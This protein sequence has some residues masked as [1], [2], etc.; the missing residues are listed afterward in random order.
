MT[1]KV[2]SRAQDYLTVVHE[3]RVYQ[4]VN[5]QFLL[6]KHPTESVINFLKDLQNDYRK[7]LRKLIK[8]NKTDP[9]I[10]EVVARHFR[11]KMAINTIKNYDKGVKAA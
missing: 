11:L 9:Q 5:I 8:K 4:I 7:R 10:N 6:Q 1:K 3:D 2:I